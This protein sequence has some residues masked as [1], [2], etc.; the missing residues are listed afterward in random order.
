MIKA[1]KYIKLLGELNNQ[2]IEFFKDAEVPA[3][4]FCLQGA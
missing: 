1:L 3:G 2:G 4:D